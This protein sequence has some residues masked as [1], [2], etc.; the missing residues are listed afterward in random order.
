MKIDNE[1]IS[2][3]ALS[4]SNNLTTIITIVVKAKNENERIILQTV[5]NGDLNG[6]KQLLLKSTSIKK[7]IRCASGCTAL[8][9]AAGGG[10]DALLSYILLLDNNNKQYYKYEVNERATGKAFGRTPLHYAARNG[11]L[12]TIQLLIEEYGA[13]PDARAKHGVTPFQLA[14]WQNRLDVCRYLVHSIGVNPA[15]VNDFQCGAVHW[16]GLCPL[17]RL[18]EDD[19]NNDK[20]G[21]S[22]LPML[23]WLAGLESIS[24]RLLQK[25]GHT[26]L[27]KAAWGGHLAVV[28]YL[29]ETIGLID[30][31][32][33]DA[34][35]Y[36]A[37]LADMA[38]TARHEKVSQYLRMHC[39]SA[40]YES[41][42][43]LGIIV[44]DEE[45][46]SFSGV[47]VTD[48]E[49]RRAYLSK[50]RI[51]H[52]DR[53]GSSDGDEFD[54]IRRAYEHL[55]IHRGVGNQSNVTHSLHLMLTAISQEDSNNDEREGS[56]SVFKAQLL[57]VL[58][59]FGDKGIELSNIKKKW[60]QV[61]MS[62]FPTDWS[63]N[64]RSIRVV[65]FIKTN[66]GDVVDIKRTED[67]RG[68]IIYPKECFKRSRIS[69][70]CTKHYKL[71]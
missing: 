17:Y 37:D 29:K 61:W 56:Q 46:E 49:I 36:A 3:N 55:I 38:H 23:E 32:P 20:E 64:D 44:C 34:G 12:H 16:V 42:R 11:H 5:A 57:S 71:R 68:Y 47:A 58:L 67:Q 10:H 41:L 24:F 50:A 21:V 62:P 25:Q 4:S 8:H 33:D 51:L 40:R 31:L 60:K 6:Y 2:I 45:D 28:R 59:E 54:A 9:Y 70:I 19:N 13:D 1:P 15:Q 26:S 53:N 66:A 43:V 27:H 39:S 63:D 7:K 48:E 35:N 52:P 30:N 65:D 14:V 18:S 69:D 22:I